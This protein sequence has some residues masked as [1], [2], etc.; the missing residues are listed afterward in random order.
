MS[1]E[2]E[3]LSENDLALL[4]DQ[5]NKSKYRVT[6]LIDNDGCEYCYNKIS[7]DGPQY[8]PLPL[9]KEGLKLHYAVEGDDGLELTLVEKNIEMVQYLRDEHVYQNETPEPNKIVFIYSNDDFS[10]IVPV[11]YIITI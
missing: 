1:N 2:L 9:E 6:S 10:K 4:D 7:G 11:T 3:A 5:L 8:R